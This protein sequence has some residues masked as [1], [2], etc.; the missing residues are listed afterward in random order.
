MSPKDGV[1]DAVSVTGF[2]AA[3]NA[4]FLGQKE[5]KMGGLI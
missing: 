5:Y 2:C 1:K 3:W 4:S